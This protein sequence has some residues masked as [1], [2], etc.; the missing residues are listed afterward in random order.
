[1]LATDPQTLANNS[2]FD[3]MSLHLYSNVYHNHDI[4]GQMTQ[5]VQDRV[6]WHPLW[7]T[8]PAPHLG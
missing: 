4:A 3:V 7:L 6:G 1:L 2:Y 8:K 5:E